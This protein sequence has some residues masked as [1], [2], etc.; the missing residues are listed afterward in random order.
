MAT[1]LKRFKDD[2]MTVR[3]RLKI[4]FAETARLAFII[5]GFVV[6]GFAINI[7]PWWLLLFC[8][9]IGATA[10]HIW[11]YRSLVGSPPLT[12][13]SLYYRDGGVAIT[14]ILWPIFVIMLFGADKVQE[15]A[16]GLVGIQWRRGIRYIDGVV[17]K[18]REE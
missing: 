7:F 11:L 16:E 8:W 5:G 1:R 13:F 10:M 12:D 6:F 18:G 14:V 9:L 4:A 2:T 17:E 3:N 15:W